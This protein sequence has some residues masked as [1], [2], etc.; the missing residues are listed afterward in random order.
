[1]RSWCVLSPIKVLY[2]PPFMKNIVWILL[3]G[4]TTVSC[5]KYL[6]LR[7][8]TDANLKLEKA[9]EYYAK[10]DYQRALPLLEDVIGAFR[11]TTQHERVYY[12]YANSYY[13]MGDYFF[14]QSYLSRFQKTFP[15][16]KFA[17]ECAFKSVVCSYKLSPEPSLD[18]SFTAEAMDN[19][20]LFLEDFPESD[21]RDT[22]NV[23]M[24]N[25]RDKLEEKSYLNSKL[26]YRTLHYEAAIISLN[27]TLK[28]YPNTQFEEDIRF[29]ILRSNYELASN[30]VRKKKRSRLENTIKSYEKYIDKFADSKR[31]NQAENLYKNTVKELESL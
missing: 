21:R 18:Q 17:E 15:R 9:E 13:N 1:M 11:G 4:L 30:S 10:E 31:A 19:I 6:K 12:L 3:L 7:K 20:Q 23:L 24:T 25:L 29:M 2:L 28:D 5:S 26:Y 14:A 8:S 27:N 16:S 22:C